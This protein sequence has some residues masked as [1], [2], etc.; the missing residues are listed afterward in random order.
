M[1]MV[2]PKFEYLSCESIEEACSLLGQYGEEARVLSGGT[3]LLIKMKHKMMT[4]GYL[5]NI[6]KIPDLTYIRQDE[7]HQIRLGALTTV[8]AVKNS[9]LIK[10]KFPALHDATG[11]FPEGSD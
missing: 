4:P 7:D 3:D 8:H 9:P 1:L 11:V 10:N 2:L 5:V 6:K